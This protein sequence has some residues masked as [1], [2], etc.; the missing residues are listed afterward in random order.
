MLRPLEYENLINALSELREQVAGAGEARADCRVLRPSEISQLSDGGLVEIG[1][2]TVTHSELSK[3]TLESQR[4]EIAE[5]RRHLETIIGQPVTSFSYPYGGSKEIGQHGPSLAKE[6][7]Y[8]VACAVFDAPVTRWSDPFLLPRISVLD[9]SEHEFAKRLLAF[10]NS[11]I[12]QHLVM[13]SCCRCS[14]V[15]SERKCH[16]RLAKKQKD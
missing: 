4:R 5:S 11:W 1:A 9:W 7:G 14:S 8:H 6:A 12:R 16:A 13:V 3:L 15:V 10:F 2:H